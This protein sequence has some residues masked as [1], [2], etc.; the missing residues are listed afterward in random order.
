MATAAGY[1]FTDIAKSHI[2]K[3]SG[4]I[5]TN[6]E[7]HSG[8]NRWYTI[9]CMLPIAS[10][11]ENPDFPFTIGQCQLTI[12]GFGDSRKGRSRL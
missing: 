6:A 7:E 11:T 10:Q 8:A 2:L 1:G 5:I 12:F 9:G 3:W 4:E